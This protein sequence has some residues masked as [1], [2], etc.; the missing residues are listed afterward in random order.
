VL[1]EPIMEVQIT[2][3]EE[4]MGDVINDISGRRGRILRVEA[5]G[6]FQ[7]LQAS[8][9]QAELFKY[10]T[11]LRS[12]TGGRATFTM[13]HSHYEQV[14]PHIQEKIVQEAKERGE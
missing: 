12:I 13:R 9:P 14:P 11:V 5:E 6:A 3:P 10:S 1:L 7:K 2:C 8:I 4:C